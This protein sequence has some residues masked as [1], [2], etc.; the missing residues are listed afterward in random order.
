MFRVRTSGIFFNYTL[1]WENVCETITV[2]CFDRIFRPT[3]LF[4]DN[5]W[6]MLCVS[7]A[8]ER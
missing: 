8:L 1:V 2:S 7:N 4:A 5:S 6:D 3:V